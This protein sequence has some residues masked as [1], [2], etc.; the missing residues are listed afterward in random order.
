MG[1]RVGLGGRGG[2]KGLFPH[3]C[4]APCS[5]RLPSGI[6]FPASLCL[7]FCVSA[8]QGQRRR[9]GPLASRRG[10][11][12]GGMGGHG[13]SSWLPSLAAA[14]EV[15]GRWRWWWGGEVGCVMMMMLPQRR[16]PPAHVMFA[17]YTHAHTHMHTGEKPQAR[18][19]THAHSL[20]H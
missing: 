1:C 9:T 14:V 2:G 12:R 20:R 11:G 13:G 18:A 17:V 3:I 5:R 16:L 8:R 7:S 6:Y 15:G 19:R 10:S 4:V